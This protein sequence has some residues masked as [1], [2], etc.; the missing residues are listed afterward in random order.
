MERREFITLLGGV[1]AIWPLTARAQQPGPLRRIGVLMGDAASDPEGQSRVGA[2]R[3]GLQQLG[4]TEGRNLQI[5]Y[6]WAGGDAEH[7]RAFATELVRLA[8]DVI[9]AQAASGLG[10]LLHETKTIPIVFVGAADPVGQ[11]FI[12]SLAHP[13]GNATGFTNFE[14][15]IG[16]KWLELLKAVEP[17]LM[18]VAVIGGP[19]TG[20]SGWFRSIESAAVPFGV[21]VKTAT[22]QN[23]AQIESVITELG[24]QPHGALIDLPDVY[25]RNHRKV[26][27]GLTA[28]Y[29]IPAVYPVHIW[30]ADGGLMSYGLDIIHQYQQAASYVDRILKG[31]KPGELPVQAPTKFELIINLN[32]A[33]ALGVVIPPTLLSTADEVI[34]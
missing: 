10:A 15:S 17:R 9:L 31:A 8:P 18:R 29:Q 2:F 33:K 13:G 20:A 22:V 23:D 30:A 5:E 12:A 3:Q 6:R 34:E 32:T 11:G 4:W 19:G 24:H 28:Q 21:E 16:G 27:I 1:T 26:I 14:F 7:T 25:T